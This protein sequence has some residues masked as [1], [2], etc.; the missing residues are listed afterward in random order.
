[1]FILL[2][3]YKTSTFT[4][5]PWPFLTSGFFVS[6]AVLE[7][8]PPPFQMVPVKKLTLLFLGNVKDHLTPFLGPGLGGPPL[9]LCLQRTLGHSTQRAGGKRCFCQLFQRPCNGPHLPSGSEEWHVRIISRVSGREIIE[10]WNK[11][12]DSEHLLGTSHVD[13]ALS[14]NPGV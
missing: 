1:M 7:D 11:G 9:S 8:L 5:F 3:P 6:M 12:T 14:K 10:H 4:A 13:L 2:P